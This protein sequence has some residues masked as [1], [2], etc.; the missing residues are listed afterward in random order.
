VRQRER[1]REERERERQ[2]RELEGERERTGRQI[3]RKRKKAFTLLQRPLTRG[4]E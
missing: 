4:L 3:L 1:E 2:E